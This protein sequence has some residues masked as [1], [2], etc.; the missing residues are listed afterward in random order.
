MDIVKIKDV[1]MDG[2]AP[3]VVSV[4]NNNFK[5][6]YCYVINWMHVVPMD[7]LTNSDIIRISQSTD[8]LNELKNIPNINIKTH[9][10]YIDW[11]ITNKINNVQF[12]RN[13]NSYELDA[14]VTLEE[15]KKF[16]TWLSKTILGINKSLYSEDVI[17]MLN[18]YASE[19]FDSTVNT[20]DVMSTYGSAKLYNLS[21]IKSSC[22]CSETYNKDLQLNTNIC[23]A[24]STYREQIYNLMVKK[25][26]DVEFWIENSFILQDFKK[27]V[28]NII[29][30]NLPLETEYSRTTFCGCDCL[31]A[32][33]QTE[34]MQLLKNL[35]ISLEYIINN[36]QNQHKQFVYSSLNNWASRLYEKMRW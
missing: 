3:E 23:N 31:D 26:S 22:A 14:D 17:V 15:L 32:S 12:Y 13:L 33:V 27:Y 6:K 8:I 1:I 24:L 34:N 29:N 21:T 5:N 11:D 16:R 7:N 25:F 35:S 9:S 30:Y 19:M 28:D 36:E 18:Y 10:D 2:Y 4:F 20:L